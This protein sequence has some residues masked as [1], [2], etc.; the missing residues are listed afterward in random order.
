MDYAKFIDKPA[1]QYLWLVESVWGFTGHGLVAGE[2][3]TYKSLIAQELAFAVA[4]G[5]KFLGEFD[6]PEKGPVILIQRENPEHL[7]ADRFQKMSAARG[8]WR[9]EDAKVNGRIIEVTSPPKLP[10]RILP[11]EIPFDLRVEED[12]QMLCGEIESLKP[13]L[14][15]LDPLYMMARGMDENSNTAVSEVLKTL[16]DIK[17]RYKVGILLV[18]HFNKPREDEGRSRLN[19]IAGAGGF[20]R[21]FE[22]ALYLEK[23]KE[24]GEVYMI[25]EHR[26]AKSNARI[27]VEVDI[28]EIGEDHYD[29]HV[30]MQVSEEPAS[31]VMRQLEDLIQSTGPDGITFVGAEERLG[32]NT[33]RLKRLAKAS[34]LIRV[35]KGRADGKAGRPAMRMYPVTV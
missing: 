16:L 8:V 25:P 31:S 26:T 32:V 28:G 27:K 19:R 23:G 20:G 14:V 29:L 7:V 1:P 6:V 33:N 11:T 34:D 3:K 30:E 21:W 22:S 12:I 10:I 9:P 15:V 17:N 18:H 5:T 2:P 35:G 4:S 13:K 24:Y